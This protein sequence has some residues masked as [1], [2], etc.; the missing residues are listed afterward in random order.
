MIVAFLIAV[1]ALNAPA[2]VLHY[3][4]AHS[5]AFRDCVLAEHG[6]RPALTVAQIGKGR[7]SGPRAKLFAD[8]HSYVRYG[9]R[10][11]PKSA[12]AAKRLKAQH[13]INAETEVTRFEAA[14][15]AWLGGSEG[16]GGL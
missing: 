12:G 16:R 13:K 15:E 1:A 11:V 7:C 8:A 9:W 5:T 4:Q 2:P 14:L 6:R 10:G 3:A